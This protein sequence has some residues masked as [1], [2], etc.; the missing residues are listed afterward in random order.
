MW[1]TVKF[2]QNEIN[3]KFNNALIMFLYYETKNVTEFFMNTMVN[4]F[5]SNN[6]LFKQS[7][8]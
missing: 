2:Y 4:L 8:L 6:S 1:Q 5:T 3:L 7:E